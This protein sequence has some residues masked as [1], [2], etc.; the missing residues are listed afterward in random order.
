MKHK[1]VGKAAGE[2]SMNVL[3]FLCGIVTVGFVLCLCIYLMPSG[4]PA[5]GKIGF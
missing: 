4:I 2:N 3:F 1:S 5:I